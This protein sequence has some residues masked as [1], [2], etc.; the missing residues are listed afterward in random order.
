MKIAHLSD[1]HLFALDEIK[2]TRLLNKRFSGWVNMKLK[3]E[4]AHQLSAVKHVARAVREGNYDHVV[5]TGDFSN[6]A[7]QQEFAFIRQFLDEQLALPP[8]RV[9]IVPGNH[10][11]YTRGSERSAR[12]ESYLAP[13]ITSELQGATCSIEEEAF[14]FVRL[15][16]GVAIIGLDSAVPRPPLVAAG[17]LGRAQRMALRA[18]LAHEEVR[19]RTPVLLIHHPIHNPAGR[20]HSY[21]EGLRDAHELRAD[22]DDV[23]FGLALHGHLHRRIARNLTTRAGHIEVFGSTSASLM[24]DD[25]DRRSGYNVYTF[26]ENGTFTGATAFRLEG[27]SGNFTEVAIARG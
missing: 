8:D 21:M 4:H 20:L 14:P 15:R 1:L 24:V 13:Y 16:G 3:R 27:P 22:L 5:I 6:L 9:S 10:D 23:S 19:K 7:L 17:A 18:I 26:E 2:P 12:F 25:P 11:R